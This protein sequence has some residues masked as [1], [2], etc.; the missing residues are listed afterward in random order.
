[1]SKVRI[2]QVLC[3]RRHCIVATAYESPDGEPMPEVT[4]RLKQQ[5]DSMI[6][7]GVNPWCGICL[8]K[9]ASW[10]YEDSPT[11]FATMKAA[12]PHLQEASDRNKAVRE[13]LRASRS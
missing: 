4:D 13:Y 10:I 9:K 7:K 2:V 12:L 5:T 1:M 8:A 3:P 11:I 6:E